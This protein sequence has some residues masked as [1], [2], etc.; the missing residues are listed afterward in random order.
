MYND[1]IYGKN[2]LSRIVSIEDRGDG[3]A[4][5]F[6]EMDN[7]EVLS[8][9]IDNSYYIL[10]T[11]QHSEKF[12]R[13][14][15]NQPYCW[16]Y[17]T[18]DK[19]RYKNALKNA[20]QYRLDKHLIR[21]SK[22]AVMIRD[23]YTYFKEMKVTDVSVLSFDIETSGLNHDSES[24]IFL[25]SNTLRKNGKYVRRL[26]S[27][28]DYSNQRQM[29]DSW[30]EWVREVNP[31]IILGHNLFG[32]DLPY[33]QHVANLWDSDLRLGRDG[34]VI[35][36]NEYTSHKRKDGSQA[37]DYTNSY[38]YGR[39]IVD[40]YFVALDYDVKRDYESYGLKQIIKQEGLERKDRQHYDAGQIGKDW[41]D[42]IKRKKI[43][44]YAQHDADDALSLF[45]FMIPARFYYAQSI[46]RS[47]QHIINSATGSQIN[48]L[49]VRAY[50]QK[51]HSIARGCK[52][53]DLKGAISF[54]FPGIYSNVLRIDASSLYPSIIRQFKIYHKYKDP[55]ALFLKIV[56]YFTLERLKNK[57]LAKDTGQRYYKDLSESQKIAI[58]SM[59]GFL[60]AGNL[61]Y[62]F[63][64]GAD[65]ILRR[66]REVLQQTIKHVTGKELVLEQSEVS[67]G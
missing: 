41:E 28:D 10:F 2:E 8:S 15:G 58:N 49:M 29:L 32:F 27:L 13:L 46:P 67:S 36:F 40:T 24:V 7:G 61:N 60:G 48:S 11:E 22:E 21:D 14:S 43:K 1:L 53:V 54:S 39:E 31:S 12:K 62:N 37:Y 9:I 45:D 19:E 52:K 51:G 55:Q 33:L 25:I 57:R 18:K 42:P 38:I 59:F 44:K 34:S 20:Y 56:E 5:I 17:E 3:T 63:M 23:G 26:F 16:L 65:E 47:F 6:R 50:F 4:E 64:P 30:C 35:R 66:G